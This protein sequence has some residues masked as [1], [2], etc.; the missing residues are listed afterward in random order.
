[1]LTS[2]LRATV[3]GTGE[4]VLV[5]G[6]GLGTNQRTWRHVVAALAP[7]CRLVRFDYAGTPD[8]DGV[9]FDFDRYGTLHGHADDVLALLDDLDLRDATWVGHSVSGTIGLIAA[10][11][12]P[13][14]IGRVVTVSASP[15][16]LDDPGTGYVGGFSAAE[17]AEV[18]RAAAADYHAWV[19]GFSPL[20][21]GGDRPGAVEEFAS[22]LRRMRPDVAHRTLTAVFTGDYRAVL[23]RVLQPVTV[24]QPAADVAVPTAVGRYLAA[25]LPN[26]AYRELR[27][28]G[29][30]P[31][32][33]A[34]EELVPLLREA[35]A[36]AAA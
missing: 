18:L 12:A 17:V 21:V 3:A 32:L 24:V 9:E 8:A 15:R 11:A 36:P 10:A 26:A 4:R 19:G 1:M 35:V 31:Q 14:R 2:P 33:T 25:A 6:N 7:E 5:L 20:A 28:E 29:H 34:P 30:V 23:P 13:E 27:A 16:Y 22:S